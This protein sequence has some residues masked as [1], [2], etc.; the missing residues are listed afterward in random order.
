M[1]QVWCDVDCYD[2]GGGKVFCQ[3]FGY[4]I[5]V[6]VYFQDVFWIRYLC[7][8][9]VGI[10]VEIDVDGLVQFGYGMFVL[11]KKLMNVCFNGYFCFQRYFGD[12]SLWLKWF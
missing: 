4:G 10:G 11:V 2:F 7:G 9:L 1:F 6:V 5:F 12:K 3:L 8:D